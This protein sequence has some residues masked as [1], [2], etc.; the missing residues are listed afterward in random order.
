MFVLHT[1]RGDT[2]PFSAAWSN[3]EQKQGC[4]ELVRLFCLALDVVALGHMSEAWLVI[5]A[6]ASNGVRPSQSPDR[7][8]CLVVSMQARTA[9]GKPWRRVDVREIQRTGGRSG[10]PKSLRP[11]PEIVPTDA[12]EG[13]DLLARRDPPEAIRRGA[14]ERLGAM[15][16]KL[17]PELDPRRPDRRH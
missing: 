13:I 1:S 17:P 6:D 9:D 5:G 11:I 14:A 7:L 15:G 4:H 10:R 16:V 2:V 8:E 12:W 3:D